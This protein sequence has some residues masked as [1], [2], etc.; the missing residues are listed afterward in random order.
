MTQPAPIIRHATIADADLLSE[1]GS[2]TFLETFAAT[3]NPEDMAAYLA[4]TFNPACQTEE[5]ADPLSVF[6]IAEIDGMAVGYARIKAGDVPACVT[7][8]KPIELVRLYVSQQWLGRGVGAGLMQRCIKEAQQA[9]YSTMWLGVWEHNDRA[10]DFY[11]KWKFQDVGS[12][13]FQLGSDPQ[14]DILMERAI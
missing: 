4:E 8:A 1:L 11:R 2:R 10:R 9:G 7:G 12:H 5:I 13:I 14:T 3:N 6:L